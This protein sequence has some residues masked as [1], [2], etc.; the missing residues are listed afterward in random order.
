MAELS[1]RLERLSIDRVIV[2]LDDMDRMQ[3]GE[4]RMLLKIIR[5]IEN[6]PKLC[7]ICAF[8]KDALVEAVVRL[9][10]IDRLALD[11]TVKGGASATG[12]LAGQIKAN[13][14]QN[15]YEYL[16]KF[17]PVQIPVPKLDHR[18]LA[19]QFDKHFDEFASHY[20][21]L[22]LPDEQRAFE[23]RFRS[24]WIS[25]FRPA[26]HNVRRIKT[27]FN[28]LKLAFRLIR[29]EVDLIDFMCIEL[30]R[31]EE[32]VLYQ[33]IYE[34]RM[35]FYFPAWDIE[36][37]PE[38]PITDNQ[39]R[40]QHRRVFDELFTPLQG[41]RRQYVLSMLGEMFPKL[42]NYAENAD[43]DLNG[44]EE[45]ADEQ[46]RICHPS[47]FMVYF[48]LHVPEGY[49]S[50]EE[51]KKVLV[52]ANE[53]EPSEVEEYFQAYLRNLEELKRMRFF[54]RVIAAQSK[55][56]E[57]AVKAL[58]GAIARESQV[59][60]IGDFGIGDFHA[61]I[62]A[63]FVIANRF[64]NTEKITS[65]LRDAILNSFT[66]AFAQRILTF[67]IDRAHN[68]L[69]ENWANV[70]DDTLRLAFADRMKLKYHKG[71][72][73]SVYDAPN[74]H[75]WQA[76]IAWYRLSADDVR[77]YLADEFERRPQNIGKH[78]LWLFPSITGSAEGK[79]FVDELFSLNRLKELAV[80]FGEKAYSGEDQRR[81]VQRLINNE[82]EGGWPY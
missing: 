46:K 27:F 21:L 26:L 38:R 23:E 75:H 65:I 80:Q 37:F 73:Y 29:D 74:Y 16:E 5:G 42:R 33:A 28:S 1:T 8:N 17:F 54:E 25:V 31:Q 69:I 78:L 70:N 9:Q 35:F 20:G 10:A 51:F 36:L 57:E 45:S 81:V 55:F 60:Q 48:S 39:A 66:D 40:E 4:L 61:A 6:Y 52:F 77:E 13:D 64:N 58:A 41:I 68:S 72:A 24:L 19:R 14:T 15:G 76:L 79:R 56:D 82:L 30:L 67:S 49:Y 59:L 18:Q 22:A 47:H 3:Q 32:P 2:L 34:H 7:F 62:R 43:I 44:N 50:T 53:N 71:G 12:S 63:T 11:F